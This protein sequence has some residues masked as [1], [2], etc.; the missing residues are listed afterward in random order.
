MSADL[1]NDPAQL[2]EMV[3][4]SDK[5]KQELIEQNR[6]LTLQLRKMEAKVQA[7]MQ[8]YFGRSSETL[9]PNQLQ[10]ALASAMADD[11]LAEEVSPVPAK[12]RNPSERRQRRIEDLPLLETVRLEPPV[13]A[14]TAPDGTPLVVIREEI[15]EEVDYRPGMLF[16]RQIIRPVYAS[17]SHAAAPVIAALPPR[18]IPGGQVGPGLIAHVVIAKYCDHVPI[19][20]QEQILARMGPT[21]TRQAMGQWVGHVTALFTPVHAALRTDILQGRYIQMDETPISLLDPE[22]GGRARD[23][24]LWAVHAPEQTSVIFEFNKSRS[25]APPKAL[26]EDFAGVLQTDGFSAYDTALKA[27]PGHRIVRAACM[28]H[29]RRGFVAALQAGDE[30]ATPFLVFFGALYRLEVEAKGRSPADRARLRSERSV[31]IL[32]ALHAR[33]RSGSSDLAILP[34]SILGK[35]IAYCLPRWSELTLFAEPDYGHVLIDNNPTERQIRPTKLGLKNWLF[36]GHPDAGNNPA[37]LYS[38]IGTCKLLKIDPWA[39][40]NWALPG[41]AAATNKTA[42]NFTPQRFIAR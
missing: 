5:Q 8:Q 13:E 36:V 4:A 24:W 6:I 27:L 34:Q 40:F 20:R 12:P 42:G 29:A 11:A 30:R 3:V 39:Y 41:L 14:R 1:P 35:A 33:L 7:L 31:P 32:L 28:A 17:P 23:A 38:I 22:R 26:L 9:D 37:I 2:R 25:H 21:F 16:R 19:H 10:L 18:V 15:T